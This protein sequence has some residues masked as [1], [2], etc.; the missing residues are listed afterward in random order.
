MRRTTR[1]TRPASSSTPA[2]TAAYGR[3]FFHGNGTGGSDGSFS[4][5][6]TA[7]AAAAPPQG[8]SVL[9][10]R[11][12]GMSA[13]GSTAVSECSATLRGGGVF[14]FQFEVVAE[15]LQAAE[16]ADHLG[17]ALVSLSGVLRHHLLDYAGDGG[18]HGRLDFPYGARLVVNLLAQQFLDVR[19]GEGRGAAD[20]AVERRA[21]RVDVRAVVNGLALGLFGGD[22]VGRAADAFLS[23]WRLPRR[24][25]FSPGPGRISLCRR[26]GLSSGCRA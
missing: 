13:E 16:V 24:R 15:R 19:G 8:L 26:P 7:T 11:L 12:M 9:R 21:Q 10:P 2:A 23:G 3:T 6:T 4:G 5:G 14:R 1:T 25:C 22:V 20:H 18:R 17:G